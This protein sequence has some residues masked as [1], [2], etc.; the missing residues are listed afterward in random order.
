MTDYVISKE[1]S[2]VVSQTDGYRSIILS[3]GLQGPPGP[4]GTVTTEEAIVY[5][6]RI[7]FIND[8]LLY[9]G[10]AEVG[11]SEASALWRIRKITIGIDGDIV[12]TWA[13][14][15]A[16]FNKIWADRATYTYS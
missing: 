1:E 15:S 4:P 2:F 14:G 6:K 5:S 3:P 10:E 9:R 16:D 11:S 13:S 7:D 8:N 12:E